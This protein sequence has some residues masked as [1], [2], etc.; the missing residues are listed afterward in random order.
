MQNLDSLSIVKA[1]PATLGKI[2]LAI[3]AI[4]ALTFGLSACGN[5]ESSSGSKDA[6]ATSRAADKKDEKQETGTSKVEKIVALDWRYE[7]ILTALGVKP[8]GIVEIGKSKEPGTLA[9]KLTEITSVGQAK[10]PNLEIISSLEPDLILA[11]PTRHA[12]I[13]DQ[14]KEIAPTEAYSDATY[15][16]VL[17]SMDE[18]AAKVGKEDEAKKVREDL[19]AKLEEA[20][21]AV[22][23]GTR[24]ALAGWTKNT[25]YTWV[26]ASF[27]ASLLKDAG[28]EYGYEGEKSNIESKTDVAELTAD[29]LPE[30]NLDVL[31]MY[32]DVDGFRET[33]FAQAVP[34]IVGVE[35][36]VWSRARGPLAAEAMLDQIIETAK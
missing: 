36:D 14:L 30:M 8:V 33:P 19:K 3:I 6:A 4:V 23:P 35:Q 27:P 25:L 22:K 11:S 29:K 10:Q 1:A 21:K 32:L 17:K 20:K 13:M 9:G 15:Q 16:D 34:T 24:A 31:F 26:D 28:F 7:E 5:S 12:A 2:L 18:I